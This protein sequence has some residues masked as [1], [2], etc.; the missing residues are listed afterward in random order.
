MRPR[1]TVVEL[2]AGAGLLSHAFKEEGFHLGHAVELEEVAAATYRANLGPHIQVAD[3]RRVRPAGRCDVL[4]AGPPCQGFSS[5][6]KRD[7]HDPRNLLSLQVVRWARVLRPEVVVIENVARFIDSHVWFRVTRA[8]QRLGYQTGSIVVNAVA[9]GAP[10]LRLRSFTFAS[11]RNLPKVKA[12]QSRQPRTVREA[13]DGLPESP[14][15]VNNHYAAVPSALAL[16]RIRC[17]PPGGDK[18][19]IMRRAPSL[20]PPSW[21]KVTGEATDVWGRMAWDQPSNTLR[22]CLYN[23]SKGRYIHPEQDRVISLR[24]AARLQTIPDSYR[25]VGLPTQIARQIGNSVPP[26][27]GRAVAR[28]VRVALG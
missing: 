2:F 26:A 19:D 12:V 24:E 9:F 18:R 16:A 22:T 6:G 8:L 11:R 1:P 15:G 14:D 4:V 23:P 21:W 10:Q 13:W 7:A 25:L 5:L 3:V 27:L 28:A 20:A 17:V